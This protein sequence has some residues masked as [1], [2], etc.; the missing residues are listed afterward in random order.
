MNAV[1]FDF[2][3]TQ[4]SLLSILLI[5][6][7]IVNEHSNDLLHVLQPG[8]TTAGCASFSAKLRRPHRGRAKARRLPRAPPVTAGRR[9]GP[10]QLII[11]SL[12]SLQLI[13][14]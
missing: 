8:P 3:M 14:S 5:I 1:S 12:M 7:I 9:A 11:D 13:D 6:A 4:L 2:G 10:D